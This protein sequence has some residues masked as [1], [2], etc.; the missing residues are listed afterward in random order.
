MCLRAHYCSYQDVCG[1]WKE[2]YCRSA[3]MQGLQAALFALMQ[4]TSANSTNS[5]P[6]HAFMEKDSIVHDALLDASH[7]L[8]SD[9]QRV[10]NLVGYGQ[11]NRSVEVG[12]MTEGL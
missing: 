1:S 11:A 6:F 10:N 2:N 9:E 4:N 3:S 12:S 7:E 8:D 5:T